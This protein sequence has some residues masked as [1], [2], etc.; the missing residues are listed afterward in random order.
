M[1]KAI[2]IGGGI[3]GL[4]AAWKLSENGYKVSIIE[5]EKSFGGLAKTIKVGNYFFDVGP[6][7]FLSEEK[8]IF[9]K[10]MD[11]FKNEKSAIPLKKRKVKMVFKGNYVDYPLSIKSILFQ[12][13]FI[14][15]ILS[16]LSFAKSKIR[17]SIYSLLSKKTQNEN[18]TIK[19][20][21][22][23]SFGK[24]KHQNFPTE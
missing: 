15:P 4:S 5:S 19:Q 7:A 11:L 17:T 20:W 10:V 9:N 8:E 3:T 21:A 24:S 23:N 6:H 22:I 1:K 2:V 16:S 13:G 14:S 12:M 18:L